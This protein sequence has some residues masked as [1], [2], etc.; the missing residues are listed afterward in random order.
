MNSVS[1]SDRTV[2]PDEPLMRE[3]TVIN[4]QLVRYVLRLLDAGAGQADAVSIADELALA[5]SVAAAGDAI[6]ARAQRRQQQCEEDATPTEE[7]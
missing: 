2:D 1:P 4:A 5:D 7:M 3:L 6:R